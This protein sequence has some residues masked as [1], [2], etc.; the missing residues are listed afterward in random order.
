MMMRVAGVRLVRVVSLRHAVLDRIAAQREVVRVRRDV[1]AGTDLAD[2]PAHLA[3]WLDEHGL[4][5]GD[6]SALGA[7]EL[8]QAIVTGVPDL[9]AGVAAAVQRGGI[10][11][12]RVA[13]TGG[14]YGGFMTSWLEGHYSIWKAAVA[15][16]APVSYTPLTPPTNTRV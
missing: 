11:E 13:V 6:A 15:G 16:A 8:A 12:R 4:P 5:T 9:L 10:D 7:D 14:S 2:T 3:A 1:E